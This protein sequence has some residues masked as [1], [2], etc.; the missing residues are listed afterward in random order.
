MG[1]RRTSVP[2]NTMQGP[3]VKPG[4]LKRSP[5]QGQRAGNSQ[6]VQGPATPKGFKRS[7]Q[8]GKGVNPNQ[9]KQ[10]TT[11]GKGSK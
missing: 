8:Q 5:Q 2:S 10:N 9:K 3:P 1:T 4:G 6:T 11:G 7:P